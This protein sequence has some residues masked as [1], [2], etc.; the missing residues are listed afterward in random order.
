MKKEAI[1]VLS[2]FLGFSA[3]Y[4]GLQWLHSDKSAEVQRV[5]SQAA[6]WHGMAWHG[7]QKFTHLAWNS[8][9]VSILI[10]FLMQ[11]LLD[12]GGLL[13][14][15]DSPMVSVSGMVALSGSPMPICNV[16]LENCLQAAFQ[17][18]LGSIPTNNL[19]VNCPGV[20]LVYEFLVDF[21]SAASYSKA[22]CKPW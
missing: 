12:E 4:V 15:Q 9:M 13:E 3:G 18:A 7:M 14:Q 19:T 6:D 17:F 22:H 10:L 8:A 21:C 16:A 1:A 20:S 5:C 2:A 11:Q